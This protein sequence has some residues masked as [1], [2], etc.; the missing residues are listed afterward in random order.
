M[1]RVIMTGQDTSVNP[2]MQCLYSS[3]QNLWKPGVLGYRCDL[4]PC[5]LERPTG[6]SSGENPDSQFD[7]ITRKFN[8][9]LF[10]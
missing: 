5:L 3:I 1:T 10:V 6:S 7:E 9:S 4:N 8:D 2:R